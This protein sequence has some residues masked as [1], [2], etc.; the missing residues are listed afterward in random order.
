MFSQAPAK[1]TP[2]K[3]YGDDHQLYGDDHQL[4]GDDHQLYGDDH[5][6]YGDDHQSLLL[7]AF[8][9]AESSVRRR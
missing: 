6:L 1:L 5:Q 9:F 3:L 8:I 7:S 2:F 4:Y